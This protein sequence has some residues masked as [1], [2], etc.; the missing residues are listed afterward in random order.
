VTAGEGAPT[1]L[2]HFFAVSLRRIT[3]ELPSRVAELAELN[4]ELEAF[5]AAEDAA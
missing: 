2:D 3:A 5:T 4:G 1:E